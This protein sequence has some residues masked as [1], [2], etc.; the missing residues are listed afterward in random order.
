MRR[1]RRQHPGI[2]QSDIDAR[3]TRKNADPSVAGENKLGDLACHLR[4]VRRDALGC[5]AMIAGKNENAGLAESGLKRAGDQTDLHG[6]LFDLPKRADRLRLVPQPHP[7][8]M[9]EVR[10]PVCPEVTVH[11]AP[12]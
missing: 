12:I 4:R 6:Q 3:R 9:F 11:H 10:S 8:P 5:Q 7:Q 1:Q 2:D